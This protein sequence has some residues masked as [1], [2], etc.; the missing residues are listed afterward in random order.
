[1]TLVNGDTGFYNLEQYIDEAYM[2]WTATDPDQMLT[3]PIAFLNDALGGIMKSELVVIGAD[4]GCGKTELANHIAFH[5]ASKK[6]RVYLFSLEG[7]KYE[8]IQRQKY[9]EYTQMVN[10][11]GRKDMA[12]SYRDFIQCKNLPQGIS[13]EILQLDE[14]FKKKYSTLNI[15]NRESVLNIDLFEAHLDM[16]ST[17]ADLIV[18]D[19]LHYFD[20]QTSNEH[21]EITE[22]MKRI[23]QLQDKYRLPIVLISHLRKKEKG[24]VFPDKDS[25]HG[26]SNIVKQATTAII[27]AHATPTTEQDNKDYEE[28]IKNNIYATG[29]RIAK[30]RTGFSDKLLGVIDYDLNKKAYEKEYLLSICGNQFITPMDKLNYPRWAINAKPRDYYAR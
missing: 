15:Y 23:K 9:K 3:Y 6:K 20:F 29:V 26:S 14:L 12:I 17:K 27:I 16:L 8:A 5:N 7:D 18:I 25:F 2:D 1:M 11:T 24:R 28:Q 19:H 22:I 13:E 4:S 30:S 21:S 10:R